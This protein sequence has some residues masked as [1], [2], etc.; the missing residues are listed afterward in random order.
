MSYLRSEISIA[1]IVRDSV[2][3]VAQMTRLVIGDGLRGRHHGHPDADFD[4]PFMDV[5]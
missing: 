2:L 4:Q 5:A 3:A 1:G